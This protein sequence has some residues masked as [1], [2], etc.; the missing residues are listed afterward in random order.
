MKTYEFDILL[1]DVEVVTDDQADA[2]F[3]AGCEDGTPV[4]CD[5]TSWVHFDREAASLEDAIRTA[6]EQV[7]AAGFDVSRIELDAGSAIF[8]PA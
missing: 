5:G 3:A 1:K 4:T 6:V 8:Q 2:L 7:R